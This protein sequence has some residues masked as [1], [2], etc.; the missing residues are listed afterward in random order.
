ML[1]FPVNLMTSLCIRDQ[2]ANP[3]GTP[4]CVSPVVS[5][6]VVRSVPPPAGPLGVGSPGAAGLRSAAIAC[7]LMLMIGPFGLSRDAV[8]AAERSSLEFRAAAVL[9]KHC[10]ECHDT[11]AEAGDLDLSRRDRALE[12]GGGGPSLVPGDPAAS[13]LWELVE[14]EEM[15]PASY[16]RMT[17]EEKQVLRQWLD[18][19]AVWAAEVIDPAEFSLDDS[20]PPVWLRRLTRRQYV[21]TVSRLTGVDLT[22]EAEQWLPREQRADGFTNT[23]YNLDVDLSHVEAYAKLAEL[24]SQRMAMTTFLRR[25]AD[26]RSTD[27]S[28]VDP[29]IESMASEFFRG[30]VEETET[31]VLRSVFEAVIDEGGDFETAMRFVVQTLLQSPRFLFLVERAVE[32]PEPRPVSGEELATRLSYATWGEPPD[33]ELRRAA[34]SGE[35]AVR[36]RLRAQVRRL[37]RDP[38]A[39]AHS[40]D[41]ITDWI[42]LGR[43]HNLRPDPQRFPDWDAALARDMEAETLAFFDEVAWR[44]NRPLSDL[45]NAPVTF[46]TP[47]LAQHYNIPW[48]ISAEFESGAAAFVSSPNFPGMGLPD[49][50]ATPPL[51]LYAFSRQDGDRVPDDSGNPAPLTLQIDRP[52]RVD[53]TDDGLRLRE[54]VLI[55]SPSPADRIHQAIAKSGEYSIETWV[56]PKNRGQKG[57]A[58]IISIS[59]GASTRNVTI[60]QDG[61]RYVVRYRTTR[62]DRN[63][64]PELKAAHG[65]V[66]LRWTHLVFTFD[67]S[68]TA[69]LYVNGERAAEETD[70]GRLDDWDAAFPLLIGNETGGDRG[71]LGTIRRVGI[72]DRALSGEEIRAMHER[73]VRHDLT[74][75]PP[76]GGLL[77]QA[78]VLTMGGDEASMVT[79]GLFVL[80]DLLNSRVGNPPPC[81]DSEPKPSGPGMTQRDLALVRLSDSSCAGCHSKFEPLAFALEKFD[82]IGIHRQ[83]DEHGNRLRDDGEVLFP[84]QERPVNFENSQAFLRLLAENERVRKTITRK[85]AQFVIARPLVPADDPIIEGIHERGWEHGGTYAAL[86][87]EILCSDLVLLNFPEDAE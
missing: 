36:P 9:S 38:R 16:P 7:G 41:F 77:T 33:A 71:W 85:L 17:D 82:G 62:R 64:L 2:N 3:N 37:L 70:Q 28:C 1:A 65:S 32:G 69:T 5:R 60:G 87:A 80:K 27:A 15:P 35:L 12:G 58:R 34:R 59:G 79:R 6:S 84:G 31:G 73:P 51:V 14:S 21:R 19:G 39:R 50:R 63:G 66:E 40:A 42:D 76:R 83:Q 55:A 20:P 52:E 11:A 25:H 68:G 72:Y 74:A 46:L 49:P 10:L 86:M 13:L 48:D 78:S 53:W 22:A 56:R 4:A 18:A 30:S 24:A 67:A 54:P 29:A 26:C 75:I 44:Q 45:M 57:P 43:L 81:V 23:A 8:T 47:R 61:D